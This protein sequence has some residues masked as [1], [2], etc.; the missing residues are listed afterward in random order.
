MILVG[1]VIFLH[2]VIGFG[3]F[4]VFSHLDQG[5]NGLV[6]MSASPVKNLA[7]PRC[8]DRQTAEGG[9]FVGAPGEGKNCRRKFVLTERND[10]GI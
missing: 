1:F 2:I 5:R 3:W 8:F 6:I 9:L 10:K 7:I 4:C